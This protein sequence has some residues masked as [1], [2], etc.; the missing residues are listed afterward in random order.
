MSLKNLG[1]GITP[2][3]VPIEHFEEELGEEWKK[4]RENLP[5]SL[6]EIGMDP[7]APRELPQDARDQIKKIL[8]LAG[9]DEELTQFDEH[10]E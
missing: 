9:I 5:E 2:L 10:Y 7:V 1:L 4:I 3:S 6:R 8:E